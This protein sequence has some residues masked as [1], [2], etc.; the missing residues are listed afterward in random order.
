[1]DKH[2]NY[3][4]VVEID[5][6]GA[7]TPLSLEALNAAKQVAGMRHAAVSVLLTGKNISSAVESLQ[8]HQVNKVFTSAVDG[9][10]HYSP[11]KSLTLFE[12]VYHMLNPELTVFGNSKNSLDFA[13]RAA[14][15]LDLP[16]VT[17]CVGIDSDDDGLT[18][19]KP[20]YSNNV[21]SVYAPGDSPC[22]ITLRPKTMEP[23]EPAENRQG[24]IVDLGP[25][26]ESVAD[27]YD[28]VDTCID[29]D[30]EKKLTDAELI[31]SGGRGIGGPE[32]FADLEKL[33]GLLGGQVG[34]T[35]PP[36]DLGWVSP[37]AQVGIT[38]EI[39]SPTVYIAVGVSGSFQHMAGMS[40]SK[41]IV[42]INSDP[43]ANIFKI[44]DY[45]VVGEYEEVL[46]GLIEGIE[47]NKC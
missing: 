5:A 42:A 35:R 32:G 2:H 21:L 47:K 46:P 8:Y 43:K 3:L 23:S 33:A 24:E 26:D 25:V 40:G 20:V 45:G 19:T 7:V 6:A 13:A 12:K 17:D 30:G 15:A 28:I 16:L 10:G 29:A 34:A 38:G 39:V 18:F 37:D 11:R 27:E 31:V 36:C 41:T 22:I 9:T 4:V 44:S 1:M 14:V